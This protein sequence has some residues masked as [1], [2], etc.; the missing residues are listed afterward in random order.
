[1]RFK[2]LS[3]VLVLLF[4][5]GACSSSGDIDSDSFKLGLIL[6]GPQNDHGWSQAN[7]EGAS[8]A[9]NKTGGKLITI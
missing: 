8:Y 4:T 5:L 2:L 9:V 1:M 7:F 6:V 3:F